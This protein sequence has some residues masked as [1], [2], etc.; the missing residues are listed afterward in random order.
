MRYRP[1]IDGLRAF[2]VTAVVLFHTGL[3][4]VPGGFVGVDIFFVISGYLI[5]GLIVG[6]LRQGRFSFWDFYARRTRRIYPALFVMIPVVLFFGYFILAPGEYED[7]GMS[8]IYSSAF[9]ANVYF[10]LHTGYF[11]LPAATM[12]LL[13]IWSIGVEEQFYLIW[14]LTLV[15]LWRFVRLGRAATLIALI[16]A[17]VLLALLCIVW[18]QYDVKSAFYLPFT[19]LWEFTLGALVLALPEIRKARAADALSVAGMLAMLGAALTFNDDLAYPGYYAILPCLGTIAVIAAGERSLMGRV[20]SLR[21]SVLLGKMSYSLYLWH[22]PIFVF[23]AYYVGK[24]VS[25]EKN[26]TLV[27]I[28][29]VIAFLSWRFIETPARHRRDHP[30]R[31]VALG[32]TL[33]AA[34]AALALIVVASAGFPGRIPEA[35]RA[36]G[37]HEAMGAFDCTEEIV[38]PA[39]EKRRRCIVGVPWET[40]SKRVVIWGDSHSKHLLP[41]L[42]IPARE[43]NLSIANW[44]GCPPFID[45]EA[46]QR[47]KL[48]SPDYSEDCAR[49]RRELLDWLATSPDID[50]VIISDAW[51]VYPENLYAGGLLDRSD[52]G[53]A[54]KL[55]EQ[56]LRGTIAEINPERYPVLIMGDMPRPGFNVPICAVQSAAGLWRKP[57]KKFRE[58]FADTDARPTEAILMRIASE[59]K[60][61]HYVDTLKAM[62]AGPKGCSIRVGNEIIY[63]D[64]NHLRRDLS[65]AT[66]EEIV[67]KLDL[68]NVLSAALSKAAVRAEAPATPAP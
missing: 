8:A 47:Q 19:R 4:S 29:L 27:P 62:C 41:L 58:L 3:H 26:L 57:C 6:Q 11:D 12:P 9:L 20:L 43:Q 65:L 15:L 32:A 46:L 1:D 50:L 30:R 17:T 44:G 33:A 54:L 28:A 64:T 67:S 48:N 24:D 61:I 63:S 68:R 49:V 31:H 21:P 10:W 38:L 53:K 52:P 25:P 40:A 7:L 56:G 13:H 23:Y 16:V 37:D 22:W 51:A 59:N 55:I 18:T 35:V 42:D 39:T 45:N 60:Q 2:A 36:L 66:R 5:T 14:P 34:T